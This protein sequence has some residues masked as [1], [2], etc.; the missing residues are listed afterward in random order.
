MNYRSIDHFFD[1]GMS[2]DLSPN[3]ESSKSYK[4]AWNGRLYSENGTISYTSI[5]GTVEV[6]KNDKINKVLGYI[7][8]TDQLLIFAKGDKDLV[9]ESGNIID[10]VLETKYVAKSFKAS[11]ES[12]IVTLD[13]TNKVDRIDIEVPVYSDESTSIIDNPISCSESVGD[14][15][16][17]SDYYEELFN[18]NNIKSCLLQDDPFNKENNKDYSDVIISIKKS[19]NT[20]ISEILW[21]GALN[22]NREGKIIAH[23][24]DE[25]SYYRRVY[26]TDFEN[27]AKSINLRD[28]SISKRSEKE[29]QMFQST[30][31]LEPIID[32]LGSNGMIYSGT[33]IYTY[34]LITE[35]GQVTSFSPLSKEVYIT[36]D[37]GFFQG[38][39][40]GEITNRSVRIKVNI[41]DYKN[42][43]YVELAI[44]EYQA[45]GLPT[46]IKVIEKTKVAPVVYFTHY[47]NEPSNSLIS[48]SDILDKNS[49]WQYCSDMISKSNK[50]LAVGLR[51][52]PL[53]SEIDKMQNDFMLHG[54]DENGNTHYCLI[55]PDPEKY[56]YIYPDLDNKKMYRVNKRVYSSIKVLG[57]FTVT[58]VNTETGDSISKSF[59][60]K[61]IY[62]YNDYTEEIYN[63][64]KNEDLSVIS[65]EL[66]VKL[67]NYN[68]V[69]YVSDNDDLLDIKFTF[70][71][72]QVIQD[73]DD[74]FEFLDLSVNSN[75]NIYGYQSLGF[76]N[77]NG[78]RI[79]FQTEVEEIARQAHSSFEDEK[80]I[81]NYNTPNLRRGFQKNEIYRL[82][83]TPFDINGNELFSLPIG[84]ISIPRYGEPIY[85]MDDSGNRKVLS[86]F[87]ANSF[88]KDDRLYA[89]K[90]MLKIEVRVGCELQKHI[91]MY[92]I[93]YV[94]RKDKNRSIIAQGI[95]APLQR[96]YEQKEVLEYINIS[97][98]TSDKWCLPPTGGPTYDVE[99]L[100]VF[101]TNKNGPWSDSGEERFTTS[102]DLIYFDSPEFIYDLES[103]EI[104]KNYQ[105]ER[106]A[107]LNPDNLNPRSIMNSYN[108]FGS[109]NGGPNTEGLDN[110][111]KFSRK[112]YSSNID[113][114]INDNPIHVNFSMFLER[115]SDM[116]NPIPIKHAESLGIGQIIPGTNFEESS[117]LSNN[118]MTLMFSSWFYNAFGRKFEKVNGKDKVKS[119]LFKGNN[120]AIGKKTIFIKGESDIFDDEFI[121][122]NPIKAL[123]F[124]ALPDPR[125]AT[126]EYYTTHALINIV[127]NNKASIYGGRTERAFRNNVFVPLSKTI[128]VNKETNA[129]Q[130]VIVE[131][132]T[133]TTLFLRMKTIANSDEVWRDFSISHSGGGQSIPLQGQNLSNAWMY[134]VVL[135]TTIE[136][137]L[138]SGTDFYR[139]S[140]KID[141]RTSK[142]EYVNDVYKIRNNQKRYIPIPND[143]KDD[144][145]ME[146]II[147]VSDT[148][149]YG[150]Y[151]D[152][153]SKFK[154]NNFYELDREKG[155][156]Y[157][158][159]SDL[160]DVYVI[161]ERQTSRIF[162]DEM[163]M[164]NTSNGEISIAQ[165]DGWGVSNHK[166]ISDYGTS[167][168]RAVASSIS[169][170][171]DST[172]FVF[173][174]ENKREFVKISKPLFVVNN[175][176]LEFLEKTKGK[177]II[178]SE[179]WFDFKY[180]ES[181]IRLRFD[182]GTG[183]TISYNEKMQVFNG[184]FNYNED[185][186]ISWN[187]DLYSPVNSNNNVIFSK[188][189]EGD[190]MNLFGNKY[191]LKIKTTTNNSGIETLIFPHWKGV[192]NIPYPVSRV[193]ATTSL[194]HERIVYGHH[195]RYQIHEGIH[196]L[197]LKNRTDRADLRGS[198][199]EMEV[200]IESKN[201]QK[202]S[203]Y[204]FSNFVR[205]SY[206]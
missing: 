179:S 172:G 95:S 128:P 182:D 57:N 63:W 50:L 16:D 163:S 41:Q 86:G 138:D 114:E 23:G 169:S 177:N 51:N 166:P 38:G 99:G 80:P 91:S 83:I 101:D 120:Y 126:L 115:D 164:M 181:N 155:G 141:I 106:I 12:D 147:S 194:G 178:D 117:S 123:H 24:V 74:Q 197:P 104:I 199:M 200:E 202:V 96:I 189:N 183:Y 94:E 56:R 127:S 134:G 109:S 3:R 47:G 64:I 49:N 131:G 59:S 53:N 203:V 25:N 27:T 173:F 7:A 160:N 89:Q 35:N 162:I 22:W 52:T 118:A 198:W 142:P 60:N 196:S 146:H 97:E 71:T 184:Y 13:F 187:E 157:N 79:T 161:Q 36:P 122:Q 45:P 68:L 168:R 144:P 88:V 84:D 10:Y 30:S 176:H 174:D 20:Y 66:S 19:D 98:K 167:I 159:T 21:V 34:R 43:E 48:L 61:R 110:Y 206:Q 105:I 85:E 81:I 201:N 188:L 77:G 152:A 11:S 26:F 111:P 2:D 180:K 204:S 46:D 192:I 100:K 78:I 42:Y 116:K 150:D 193:K 76:S 190:Y 6:W 191:N 75:D 58:L 171:E 125:G 149:L 17:Y 9:T 8:F 55:N 28:K 44:L 70:N 92:N 132:D 73:Y 15:I 67:V 4:E 113:G 130:K 31:L 37:K 156:A 93:C 39:K 205:N 62:K 136:P 87:Y 14:K 145:G 90:I 186:Y 185:L 151:I 124:E 195:N 175:Y 112:V 32:S 33:Y 170:N 140:D 103:S 82:S 133:Y 5:K 40:V 108:N 143:F 69:L 139:E 121:D 107:R 153:Y 1:E 54:W 129:T 158:I 165:G 72:E 65:K 154:V 102:R 29:I 119:G 148:K 135:E 18:F 137:K